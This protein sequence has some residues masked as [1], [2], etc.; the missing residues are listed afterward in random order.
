MFLGINA[1][2]ELFKT[3][4]DLD[5]LQDLHVELSFRTTSEAKKLLALVNN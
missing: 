2:E 1:L 3:S 4:T 5:I